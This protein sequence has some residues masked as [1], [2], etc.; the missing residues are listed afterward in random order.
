ML[1]TTDELLLS[2]DTAVSRSV[3]TPAPIIRER[4][5]GIP[6]DPE[7]LFAD[8]GNIY[9]ARIEKR[10]RQLIVKLS[11]VRAFLH[12]GEKV[13]LVTTA[14]S[15]VRLAEQVL[16]AGLFLDLER[17]IVVFTNYRI[18]H[19][20]VGGHDRYRQS[21]AQ[22]R[23]GDIRGIQLQRGAL[24]IAY[25]KGTVEKFKAVAFAERR[26]IKQLLPA[27]PLTRA[28][29][30]PSTRT[31][32]CSHC[33]RPLMKPVAS[34]RHCGQAFKKKSLALLATLLTPGGGYRY[35]GHRRPFVWFSLAEGALVLL[36]VRALGQQGAAALE[37]APL[38][39][40]LTAMAFLRGLAWFHGAHFLGEFIPCRLARHQW[41]RLP[42]LL[43]RRF[44]A[45][46]PSA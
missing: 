15:P 31:Q 44:Y 4:I 28:V 43:R 13:I 17:S 6:V 27:L 19:V 18:L 45:V 32:L 40:I 1:T 5:F 37:S 2:P 34:C 24:V 33:T 42:P 23:Y 8:A 35:L 21:I 10:Q 14:Y 41:L 16:T 11:F 25:K 38:W 39:L 22:I 3:E 36:A 20:P 46:R 7:V 29:L 30:S 9:R 26:K 12:P